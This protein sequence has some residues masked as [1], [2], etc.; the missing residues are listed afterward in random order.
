MNRA[1]QE[2]GNALASFKKLDLNLGVSLSRGTKSL[3]KAT[4]CSFSL[5]E[6]S[7]CHIVRVENS[8]KEIQSFLKPLCAERGTGKVK[9]NAL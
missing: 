5:F 8:K 6:R 1:L 3:T 2:H 4:D 9:S 7:L